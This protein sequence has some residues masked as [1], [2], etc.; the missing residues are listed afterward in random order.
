MELSSV[1]KLEKMLYG[2][3]PGGMYATA[4]ADFREPEA[5]KANLKSLASLILPFK[6]QAKVAA[7]A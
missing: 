6:S 4:K 2:Q 7:K 3:W 1:A 5:V